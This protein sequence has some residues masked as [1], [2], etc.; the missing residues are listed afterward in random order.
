MKKL[1]TAKSLSFLM[2]LSLLGG[3]VEANRHYDNDG[4]AEDRNCGSS[5]GSCYECGCNPLYCGAWDLQV[6][7]GVSPIIWRNRGNVL[8]V[9]CQVTTPAPAAPLFSLFELPKFS[10]LF[11]TP[12]T[13]GGQV[14]YHWSD[15]TR[16]YLEFNYIQSN[17]KSDVAITTLASGTLPALPLVLNLSKYKLFDG[18]VGVRYYWDRWCDR[19]SFF[20]GGKVGFTHR[21]RVDTATLVATIPNVGSRT[22]S[23]FATFNRRTYVSGGADF[24]LDFCFCGN[25]SFVITGAVIASCGPSGAVYNIPAPSLSGITNIIVGGVAT[26]LRFPVTAG[27]RYSF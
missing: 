11:K 19:V 17:H 7:A 3:K 21:K 8:A 6:Q 22:L 24:G 2:L 27:V 5:C 18:Y 16:A 1:L 15:N 9:D 10:S 4:Y 20:L 25:W 13:V 14:G 12:W 26:E 23:D